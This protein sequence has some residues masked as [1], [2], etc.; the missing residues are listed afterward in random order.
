[1]LGC[2]R[3]ELLKAHGG[4]QQVAQNQPRRFRPEPYVNLLCCWRLTWQSVP[5]AVF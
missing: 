4:F 5:P 2:Q 1:M 3:G